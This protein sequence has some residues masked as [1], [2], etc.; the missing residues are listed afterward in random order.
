[1]DTLATATSTDTSQGPGPTSASSTVASVPPMITPWRRPDSVECHYTFNV[2]HLT[3]NGIVSAWMDLHIDPDATTFS[4]YPPGMFAAGNSGTFSPAICPMSWSTVGYIEADD[5]V[6]G[7]TTLQC[8]SSGFALDAGKNCVRT[9][10]DVTATPAT[11]IEAESTYSYMTESVTVLSQAT[12]A[13]HHIVAEFDQGDKEAL[14]ILNNNKFLGSHP[15]DLGL[16]VKLG[17]TFGALFFVCIVSLAVCMFTRWR[18]KKD[19]EDSERGSQGRNLNTYSRNI[20]CRSS[21]RSDETSSTVD[22]SH[23]Q[24]GSGST[25]VPLLHFGIANAPLAKMETVDS[26]TSDAALQQ[27][28]NRAVPHSNLVG[29]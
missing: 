10:S 28:K 22:Y 27:E 5:D 7:A 11:Y 26:S 6:N 24:P 13:H 19:N 18:K 8:C 29:T 16:E 14:G 25:P 23:A 20:M 2:D 4:C 17:I 3:Q 21:Y 15:P 12:V 9:Y 1:M